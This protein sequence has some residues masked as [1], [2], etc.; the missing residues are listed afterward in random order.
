MGHW[1]KKVKVDAAT[2]LL[3][4][5]KNNSPDFSFWSSRPLCLSKPQIYNQLS[6]SKENV[7]MFDSSGAFKL[8]DAKSI[9]CRRRMPAASAS[10]GLCS[11]LWWRGS[12]T[13]PRRSWSLY[14][15]S[16]ALQL[17]KLWGGCYGL[18]ETAFKLASQFGP[19]CQV[20]CCQEAASPAKL[21]CLASECLTLVSWRILYDLHSLHLNPSFFQH[22]NSLDMFGLLGRFW[23][24]F[25]NKT[26]PKL[27]CLFLSDPPGL[28]LVVLVHAQP[29]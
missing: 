20:S 1:L 27:T 16:F 18:F 11:L 9:S 10:P 8:P 29:P 25:I 2:S 6:E 22:Q 24:H 13:V 26:M 19:L 17:K 14:S 3:K 28:V 23:P 15:F 5:I 21:P 4:R 12:W 7:N